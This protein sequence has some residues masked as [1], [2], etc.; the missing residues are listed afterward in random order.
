M[1]MS[2]NAFSIWKPVAV[3]TLLLASACGKGDDLPSDV[4][5]SLSSGLSSS[6]G[7]S[8]DKSDDA[9][10]AAIPKILQ[11]LEDIKQEIKGLKG[12]TITP[13]SGSTGT[14]KPGTSTS[15]GSGSAKPGTSTGSGSTGSTKPGASTS[16][17]SGSTKPST[18][19]APS[20]T[21]ELKKLLQEISSKPFVEASV[22][23][24]EKS[25]KDGHVTQGKM[26]MYTKSPNL[27]KVD[28]T[29]AST[30]AT[31]AKVLYNS[32]E[33]AK[34][35]IRPGGSLSFITTEL[36]KSDDR[37]T[38]TNDYKL[39]DIDLFGL[40][41]RLSSGYTAELVGKT[42]V[43]G[44]ELYIL[45]IKCSGTNSLDSRI[46]YEYLGYEA[47]THKLRLWEVYTA[48]SKEPY[49]RMSLSKLEYPASIPDST[50]KV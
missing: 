40:V 3:A 29:F 8:S 42:Q 13:V 32:G 6:L 22:E 35:K 45:K 11:G 12:A 9:I 49:F 2:R 4:S 7:K 30:G 1:F 16:S 33:G 46:D 5:S 39:D 36:A 25:L 26:N 44:A 48:D 28:V 47:D 10:K 31:G 38:S 19:A 50:F 34:A 41:R 15:S 37:L 27:V 21:D 18:P 43:N 24:T 17:G 23:K 14:T 20:A